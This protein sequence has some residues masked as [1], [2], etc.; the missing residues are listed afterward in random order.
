MFSMFLPRLLYI[1]TFC[2][3]LCLGSVSAKLPKSERDVVRDI[4][5]NYGKRVN[6]KDQRFRTNKWQGG[7]LLSP[8]SKSFE[9]LTWDEHFSPLGSKLST[10]GGQKNKLTEKKFPKRSY[11]SGKKQFKKPTAYM[12]KKLEDLYQEAGIQMS[13]QARLYENHRLYQKSLQYSKQQFQDIKDE[14]SLR[15]IN[16]F[17]FRRNRTDDGVP[18]QAVRDVE[19]P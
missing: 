11:V 1:G 10:V 5:R 2:G 12:G 9:I 13:D 4:V 19:T 16:R 14:V 7:T 15:D 18:V 6:L 3:L 8:Q 17:Q